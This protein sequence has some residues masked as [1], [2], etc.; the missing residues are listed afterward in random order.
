MSSKRILIIYSR[1]SVSRTEAE[2]LLGLMKQHWNVDAMMLCITSPFAKD[3]T[4][5]DIDKLEEGE[6]KGIQT[7]IEKAQGPSLTDLLNKVLGK[8]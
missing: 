5:Y 3:F 2:R 7:L 6:L 1:G 8:K 4:I